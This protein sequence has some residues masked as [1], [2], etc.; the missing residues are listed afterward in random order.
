MTRKKISFFLLL[1]TLLCLL[2]CLDLNK[3][4]ALPT[5]GHL[6]RKAL[7]LLENDT[8]WAGIVFENLEPGAS[9]P[10]PYVKYKIRMDI[11]EVERTTDVKDG[12][13]NLSM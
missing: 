6:V 9:Q 5:E 11:D 8:Y 7:E 12:Y 1:V 2:Q 13:V 4:E 10:P 3:F